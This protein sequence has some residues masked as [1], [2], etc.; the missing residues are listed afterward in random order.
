MNMWCC[1]IIMPGING[2]IAG[3]IRI[4]FIPGIPISRIMNGDV[5][6]SPIDSRATAKEPFEAVL[7]DSQIFI[8]QIT[9]LSDNSFRPLRGG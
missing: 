7:I 8:N 2:R 4:L 6:A 9:C 5:M 1:P 3:G